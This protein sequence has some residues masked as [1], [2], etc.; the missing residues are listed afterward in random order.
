MDLKIINILCLLMAFV[1]FGFAGIVSVWMGLM[2]IVD[3]LKWKKH[4]RKKMKD[5]Y[6]IRG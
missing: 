6:R 3:E 1:W 4:L 2:P 5:M